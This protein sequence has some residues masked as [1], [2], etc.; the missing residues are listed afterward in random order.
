MFSREH[1]ILRVSMQLPCG[2]GGLAQA[3]LDLYNP[4]DVWVRNEGA[5]PAAA[6]GRIRDAAW[7]KY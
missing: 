5:R 1:R 7:A 6:W 4:R 3:I 2:G